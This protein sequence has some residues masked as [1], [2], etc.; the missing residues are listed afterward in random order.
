MA[1]PLPRQLPG[2]NLPEEPQDPP[3]LADVV[4]AKKYKDTVDVALGELLLIISE[5]Y[6]ELKQ[7]TRTL[8]A[9]T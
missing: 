1:I 7:W 2:I 9:P 3:T 6:F 8:S 4:A 5:S